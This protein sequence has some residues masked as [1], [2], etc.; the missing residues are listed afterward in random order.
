MLPVVAGARETKRQ[1]VAY[2]LVLLPVAV[3]PSLL[4]VVGWFYGA[5][6][7]AL[8]LAFLGHA[9][10]VWRTADD[11]SGH[12]AARRMFRFSLVYLA[13]LFAALPLDRMVAAVAAG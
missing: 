2:C 11:A 4:G 1:M 6:A 5:I 3:A 13:V 12:P 8:G 10:A 9:V 7:A